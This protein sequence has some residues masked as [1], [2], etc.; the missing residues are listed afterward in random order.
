[1]SLHDRLKAL[2]ENPA[3]AAVGSKWTPEEDARVIDQITMGRTIEEVA[4][5]CKRTHGSVRARVLKM[6]LCMVDVEGKSNDEVCARLH[7]D[8][9]E[10]DFERSRQT[11][12][13]TCKS[14]KTLI[15]A[16][17]G[18]SFDALRNANASTRT[19]ASETSMDVLKD[20]RDILRRIEE[21]TDKHL[22]CSA[23]Q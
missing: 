13:R 14:A 10:L 18:T 8:P 7:V 16:A 17:P 11:M 22:L 12:R 5:E 23:R 21:K 9:T 15:T 4:A 6:A 3:F 1:M 19:L 2:K 20:I